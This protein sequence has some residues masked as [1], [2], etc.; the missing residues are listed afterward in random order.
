MK[1][2]LLRPSAR[3]ILTGIVIAVVPGGVIAYLAWTVASR[4][5]AKRRASH[6]L[7]SASAGTEIRETPAAVPAEKPLHS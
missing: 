5:W 1:L 4:L 6:A 2:K 7:A 3:E